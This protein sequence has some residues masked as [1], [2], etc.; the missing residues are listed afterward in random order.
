MGNIDPIGI[1]NSGT[2]LG[3]NIAG[4][5]GAK[6]QQRRAY[7]YNKKLA[8]HAYGL[9]KMA[10]DK[11]NQYNSPAAQMARFKAAG[12]N[13]NLIYGQ[14]TPGNQPQ[15]PKYQTPKAD[16]RAPIRTGEGV[17]AAYQ[18]TELRNAQVDQTR[19]N[20]RRLKIGNDLD[21]QYA[22]IERTLGITGEELKNNLLSSKNV[23]A[24]QDEEFKRLRNI[25]T[26]VQ[27]QGDLIRNQGAV[28]E[29]ELKS[30]KLTIQEIDTRIKHLQEK[31]DELRY[32]HDVLNLPVQRAQEVQKLSIQLAQL[33]L[34]R[35]SAQL[36]GAQYTTEQ[37]KQILNNIKMDKQQLDIMHKKY[38]LDGMDTAVK[39]WAILNADE[40]QEIN[41]ATLYQIAIYDQMIKGSGFLIQHLPGWIT[42]F[43]RPAKASKGMSTKDWQNTNKTMPNNLNFDK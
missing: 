35:K 30:G 12:L 28:L 42:K 8:E 29:N 32:K 7:K 24:I 27:T 20:T 34:I 22:G 21:E 43:L 18:N 19:E 6:K 33:D 41:D 15:I 39:L 13:P 40:N 25:R 10:I 26:K 23:Q 17:I 2:Q 37:Q 4:T 9:E 38:G 1:I 14:G 36:K 31:R 5:I 16:F 11:Q 3:S